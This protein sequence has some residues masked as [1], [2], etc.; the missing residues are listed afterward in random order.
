MNWKYIQ[1]FTVLNIFYILLNYKYSSWEHLLRMIMLKKQCL[2][3]SNLLLSCQDSVPP[4][5]PAWDYCP[6]STMAPLG[7]GSHTAP[8]I[9]PT[10]CLS[11][12]PHRGSGTCKCSMNVSEKNL[13]WHKYGMSIWWNRMYLRKW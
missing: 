5:P 8:R 10:S 1:Y 9:T 12:C 2:T 3:V 7:V 4:F 6:H 11:L 13:Y